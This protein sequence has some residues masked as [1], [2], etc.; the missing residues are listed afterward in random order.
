MSEIEPRGHDKTIEWE[1]KS[2][3]AKAIYRPLH[4]ELPRTNSPPALPRNS[5]PR[6]ET[7]SR[8]LFLRG[9]L[10]PKR[11]PWWTVSLLLSRSSRCFMR[12]TGFQQQQQQQSTLQPAAS[13]EPLTQLRAISTL[14]LLPPAALRSTLMPSQSQRAMLLLNRHS[15]TLPF[16]LPMHMS[17]VLQLLQI[18]SC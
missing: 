3:D 14:E 1:L 4:P 12:A 17:K 5:P 2:P 15:G 16:F 8:L 13:Q 6:Q 10:R 9:I 7:L 18:V 11:Y